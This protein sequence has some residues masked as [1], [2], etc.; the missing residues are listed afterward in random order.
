MSRLLT[1]LVPVIK[2]VQELSFEIIS[3]VTKVSEADTIKVSFVS[4]K[5]D[6]WETVYVLRLIDARLNTV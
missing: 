4:V 1:T 2:A 6:T 3:N 5:Q